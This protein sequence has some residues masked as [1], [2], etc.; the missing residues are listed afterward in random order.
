M[1]S[2]S[3]SCRRR[4]AIVAASIGTLL[5]TT[6]LPQSLL[7]A[8]LPPTL[9]E[10]AR[11]AVMA[12]D[13]APQASNTDIPARRAFLDKFQADFGALQ[14]KRYAVDIAD[15]VIAGVPVRKIMA[16]GGPRTRKI[17]IN[18]HGGGFTAD[19][20]TLTENIP[21][22]S[23]T[24]IPVI[25]VKY[26][27][28]PE[29]GFPAAVEDGLAVYRALLKTHNPQDIAIYGTSAGAVIGPQLIA[30]IRAENL[31]LPAA[32]G[33]FS[34]DADLSKKG[35]TLQTL[36]Y[37]ISALYR[38]YLGK[39]NSVDPSVSVTL[40]D[41]RGFPP[42][43]CMTSSRDFFLST[44]VNFCRSLEAAGVENKLVVF[45]GLPHAFWSFIDAPE[46]DLAFRIMATYFVDHLRGKAVPGAG[47]EDSARR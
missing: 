14:R 42:T 27:L 13:K 4:A 46:S 22:A 33:M 37:D 2:K 16:A 17:L 26:R 3:F 5:P 28:L 45:D 7:S 25:A 24:K 41:V 12:N 36:P 38:L 39:F 44:T 1:I 9:S 35:D 10:Q 40:G 29:H 21:I 8:P 18:L 43:L 32:L 11:A 30:R 15:A 20:G 47:R 34:G 19:S 31:P 6:A 23:L